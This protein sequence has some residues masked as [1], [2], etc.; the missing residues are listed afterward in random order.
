MNID[1]QEPHMVCEVTFT[2]PSAEGTH[3][4]D[5][6][7]ITDDSSS[8][9]AGLVRV[10]LNT[11]RTVCLKQHCAIL[12][13]AGRV[14]AAIVIG[15]Q[16]N[17]RIGIIIEECLTECLRGFKQACS[18]GQGYSSSAA[19]WR[20]TEYGFRSKLDKSQSC[21]YKK[22]TDASCQIQLIQEG[23]PAPSDCQ[24][25]YAVFLTNL[26]LDLHGISTGSCTFL[27]PRFSTGVREILAA[28]QVLA[29]PDFVSGF[30]PIGRDN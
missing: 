29:F 19:T 17:Q 8:Y 30:Q 20:P 14:E 16:S 9:V 25:E 4:H 23:T 21:Q 10:E 5:K 2:V 13:A 11:T 28:A 6:A 1:V 3:A 7:N 12:L 18:G 22:A 24:K 26:F 15:N 27:P